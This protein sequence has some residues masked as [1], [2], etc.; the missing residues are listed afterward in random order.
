MVT[1]ATGTYTPEHRAMAA[2]RIKYLETKRDIIVDALEPIR[3]AV[4]DLENDL[5]RMDLEMRRLVEIA[6]ELAE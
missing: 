4:E 2:E 5:Y 6:G 3:R 1:P